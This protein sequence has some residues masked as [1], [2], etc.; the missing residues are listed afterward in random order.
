VDY[1]VVRPCRREGYELRDALGKYMGCAL[2]LEQAYRV[3]AAEG[4]PVILELA[5]DTR[6]VDRSPA[7]LSWLRLLSAWLRTPVPTL[8]GESGR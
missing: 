3:A 5:P 8:K 1:I 2:T 6:R 7:L 4:D